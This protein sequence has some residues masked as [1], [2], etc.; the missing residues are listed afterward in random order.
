MRVDQQHGSVRKTYTF[1]LLPT[2]AQER[3]LATVL[4]RCGV[5]AL[6]R[7][8]VVALWRWRERSNAGLQER[9]AAWESCRVCVSCAMQSAHLQAIKAVRP[10]LPRPQRAG[11]AGC[12]APPGHGVCRLLPP[13]ASRGAPR[14]PTLAGHG[15]LPQ[16]HLSAG[17]RA[18]WA[19]RC[20]TGR[21]MLTRSQIGRL[22]LR[23]H[24]LS[25]ASPPRRHPQG[26]SP[27]AA[28]QTG[29]TRAS[30]V[31]TCPANRCLRRATRPT[32]TWA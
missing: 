19:R 32:S 30:P 5:V 13:S 14:L 18:R 9:T 10:R 24:P 6:W 17:G 27:S 21:G 7:C 1:Q 15:P 26:R 16:L 3:T 2:P 4:W 28:R 20:S 12:A 11:R 23:L 31:R 22:R 8:G 29:G 25:A